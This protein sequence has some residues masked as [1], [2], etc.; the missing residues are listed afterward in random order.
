MYQIN[1]IASKEI[2]AVLWWVNQSKKGRAEKL[3]NQWVEKCTFL[4]TPIYDQLFFEL[5][6]RSFCYCGILN[7]DDSY[8]LRENFSFCVI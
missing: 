7:L 8:F 6:K 2:I 4:E 5:M 3:I 1:F